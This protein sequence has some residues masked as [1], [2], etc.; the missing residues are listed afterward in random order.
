MLLQGDEA[1]V[2]GI[3]FMT[4]DDQVRWKVMRASATV[5]LPPNVSVY[6]G[7]TKWAYVW[8]CLSHE[9]LLNPVTHS[10]EGIQIGRIGSLDCGSTLTL[11]VSVCTMGIFIVI[12]TGSFSL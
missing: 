1:Q 2:K 3:V 6:D 11:L 4:P 10:S 9:S 8:V 7:R 12:A 5:L